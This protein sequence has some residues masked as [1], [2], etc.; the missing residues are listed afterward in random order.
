MHLGLIV[1]VF[2]FPV[3]RGEKGH[4]HPG[5]SEVCSSLFFTFQCSILRDL[6]FRLSQ[7]VKKLVIVYPCPT[8][9]IGAINHAADPLKFIGV[10]PCR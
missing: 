7:R 8:S 9:G 3:N 2:T 10:H 4:R 5:G 1:I 6:L